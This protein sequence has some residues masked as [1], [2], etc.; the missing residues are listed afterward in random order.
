[1]AIK[2]LMPKGI[3][4][5]KEK[6]NK[7]HSKRMIGRIPWNKGLTKETDERIKKYGI[8]ESKTQNYVKSVR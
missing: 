2:L 3:Y 5:R 7:K 6:N 1:M 8:E 4:K